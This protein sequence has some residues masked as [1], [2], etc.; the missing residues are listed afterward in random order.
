RSKEVQNPNPFS[1][2]FNG[3][4]LHF[5]SNSVWLLSNWNRRRLQEDA[6]KEEQVSSTYL[7]PCS[8]FFRSSLTTG[9]SL[10][11]RLAEEQRRKEAEEKRK[12]EESK[13]RLKERAKLWT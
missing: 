7:W 5:H 10:Q 2:L 1:F 13:N 11:Q 9:N 3:Q 6:F 4:L 12:Q 8:V